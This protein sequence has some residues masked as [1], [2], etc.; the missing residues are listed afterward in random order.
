MKKL[1]I[2]LFFCALFN[3]LLLSSETPQKQPSMFQQRTIED[4]EEDQKHIEEAF[5]PVEEYI[6]SQY[7]KETT[8]TKQAAIELWTGELKNNLFNYCKLR[9]ISVQQAQEQAQKCIE[10]FKK[11]NTIQKDTSLTPPT[12]ETSDQINRIAFDL[13][14]AVGHPLNEKIKQLPENR[15]KSAIDR[16]RYQIMRTASKLQKQPNLTNEQIFTAFMQLKYPLVHAIS[17][18]N[19]ANIIKRH[20]DG[21]PE[22][23]NPNIAF[24]ELQ[25]LPLQPDPQIEQVG[26]FGK[27]WK[28]ISNPF[29]ESRP[30]ALE[31]VFSAPLNKIAEA[32]DVLPE[33]DSEVLTLNALEL[34]N[35]SLKKLDS[36]IPTK[37]FKEDLSR[38]E[39]ILDEQISEAIRKNIIPL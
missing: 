36:A 14:W 22:T 2:L 1:K 37:E 38:A 11:S 15:R 35:N 20:E 9:H 29:I 17:E 19:I 39:K 23:D 32:Q 13:E 6:F 7:P 34:H 30:Q 21:V 12:K 27:I 16:Y 25:D 18:Q 10:Q 24:E 31:R 4:I 28:V 5:F 8:E 3:Q 26:F 33:K